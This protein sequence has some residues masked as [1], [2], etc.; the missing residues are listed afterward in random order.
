MIVPKKRTLGLGHELYNGSSGEHLGMYSTL[1]K[2]RKRFH[3]LGIKVN[4][5]N[6]C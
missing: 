2:V 5:E 1:A 3:S 4:I 6:W